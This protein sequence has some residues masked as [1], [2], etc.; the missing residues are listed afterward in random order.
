MKSKFVSRWY[1]VRTKENNKVVVRVSE[2]VDVDD[3]DPEGKNARSDTREF[4][5]MAEAMKFIKE[6]YSKDE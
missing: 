5:S 3:S 4:A 1:S 6:F 2:R